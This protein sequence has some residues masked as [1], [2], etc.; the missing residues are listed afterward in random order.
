MSEATTAGIGEFDQARRASLRYFNLFRLI[1]AGVF[2]AAG[3]E[4]NLGGAAPRT[5]LAVSAAYLAAV[6][7]LGFPDAVRRIGFDRIANL[8][9]VI[10]ICVLAV[11]MWASGGYR[12]GLPVLMMA[13]L[14]GSGLVSRERTVLFHAALATV[15]VLSENAW[16]FVS[17]GTPGDFFQVGMACAGFFA[18]AIVARLLARRAQANESLAA[19]RGAELAS[20]QAINER[21]IRDMQDGVIVLGADG[22]I[23]HAN[24][25]ASELLGIDL[26]EG[27]LLAELDP[28]LPACM[29]DGSCEDTGLGRMGRAGRSL[30]CRTVGAGDGAGGS[31]DTVI[32]LTDFEEIQRQIQQSKLA[33]LGRL[34][35]SMAHEIRNPLSAVSQAAELLEEEKRGD[36]QARLIRIINDNARRIER[37]VRDVL[38]LGRRDEVLPDA[39]ALRDFIVAL[40]EESCLGRDDE[41]QIYRIEIDPALTF[42]ADRAHLQQILAN[43]VGNARRYCSGSPGA[44]QLRAEAPEPGTVVLHVADDGPGIPPGDRAKIFEPF[45]T[46]HPKGTGLGLYIARELAEA[47]GAALELAPSDTGA[48]FILAGRSKP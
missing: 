36:M 31:G 3:H 24:P 25:R 43:L 13:V 40:V 19:R 23:R 46:S 42:A 45:F 18:I 15:L 27:A 21:I 16:R 28:A 34:T 12:S 26:A 1:L 5:F 6:L 33:A 38:A 10:D 20:Q 44:I 48:H 8:Q 4:L 32:Y 37:M 39:I 29:L 11:L 2:V 30:R 7:L 17:G 14:A 9:G 41:R 35:A 22:R 47:N